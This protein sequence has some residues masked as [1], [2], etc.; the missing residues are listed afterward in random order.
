VVSGRKV[1]DV[2]RRVRL[3]HIWYA[4]AHGL[5]LRDPRN[6]TYSLATREQK[7][8]IQKTR[9][10]LADSIRGARGLWIEHK[11]AT[12]ALHYRGAP[13]RSRQIARGAVE[14]AMERDPRLSLLASKKA[15]GLLPDAQSDK[16]AAVSFI[17]EREQKRDSARRWLV[18]FVGDDATDERVFARLR[19]ISVAVGKKSKTAAKYWLRSPAEVRKFLERL[20]AT[21]R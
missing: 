4:G 12:V 20:S 5:F 17:I 10:L 11:I 15:W 14:R 2:R 8:R 16:W 18:I 9:R 6:R 19:G 13:R 1:E 3:K 7:A 21:R